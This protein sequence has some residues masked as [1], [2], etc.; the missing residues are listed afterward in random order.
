MA[1]VNEGIRNEISIQPN[2]L[3]QAKRFQVQVKILDFQ[4]NLS[5]LVK[6]YFNQT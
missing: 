5:A 4:L 3:G 1:M 6:R 2:Q